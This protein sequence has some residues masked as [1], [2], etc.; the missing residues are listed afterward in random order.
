MKVG[1]CLPPHIPSFILEDKKSIVNTYSFAYQK[2]GGKNCQL[3]KGFYACL[4]VLPL[5]SVLIFCKF[6]MFFVLQHA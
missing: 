6:I 5:I 1:H 2:A 3:Q 4:F